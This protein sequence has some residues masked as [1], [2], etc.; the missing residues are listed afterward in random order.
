MKAEADGAPP[1]QPRSR[2]RPS[3]RAAAARSLARTAPIWSS[4]GPAGVPV[5]PV[6]PTVSTAVASIYAAPSAIVAVSKVAWYGADVSLA[7]RTLRTRKSTL[8]TPALSLAV[9]LRLIVPR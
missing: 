8:L 7:M 5:P 3:V 1:G 9:A 4:V 2:W 6:P